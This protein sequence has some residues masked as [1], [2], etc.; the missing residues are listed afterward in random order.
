MIKSSRTPV[1]LKSQTLSQSMS[2]WKKYARIILPHIGLILISFVYIVGGAGVF[3]FIESPNEHRIRAQGLEKISDQF[4]Q[5]HELW[6]I[7]NDERLSKHDIEDMAIEYIDNTTR[8]LFQAFDTHYISAAHLINTST[9]ENSWT[10]TT[11]IFF[12]TTLLTTIGY[13]NQAPVTTHGRLICILYALFGVPLI[14]ITVADIGKF[15]SENIIRSCDF[16]RELKKK[17]QD[18]NSMNTLDDE[19]NQEKKELAQLGLDQYGSNVPILLVLFLLISYMG[20]GAILLARWEKW[21]FFE[22]FYFSFIT[23]TTI[24]FGDI[25]PLKQQFFMFDLFYIIIG[26][27]ITT[28]CIDLAGLQYIRKIHFLGRRIKDAQ[29][30][31]I[32]V[33]G[34]KIH[35]PNLPEL[36]NLLQQKYGQKKNLNHRFVKGA[37]APNDLAV[38]RFI[39]YSA[40]GSLESLSS[41][42]AS[43]FTKSTEP[44][45][46]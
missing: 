38:I 10:M 1:Q 20:V 22:G 34:R 7:V 3:Y 9:A 18:S 25:V 39:D 29:Y 33:G 8:I 42:I 12:T 32:K 28:M 17:N 35:V 26:L 11:S 23:M 30:A 43:L 13:G 5:L 36:A 16:Y 4:E 45:M 15:F 2:A 21:S 46:V 41:C 31:L 44:S 24:G 19:E 27:A 14:L 37:Y 6:E 40:V